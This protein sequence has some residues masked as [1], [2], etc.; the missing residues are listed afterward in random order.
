MNN[1]SKLLIALALG[2]FLFKDKIMDVFNKTP[3]PI[4][5]AKE[6]FLYVKDKHGV[7]YAKDIERLFRL[8]TAHFTSGQ[9]LGTGSAGME[10]TKETFPFGWS[11]EEFNK[12]HGL[13]PNDYFI[14]YY[15][16]NHTG[17][18]TPF[19]GWK[20]TGD[21]IKFVAW[22]IKNKRNGDIL[23]WYRLPSAATKTDRENYRKKLDA[24]KTQFV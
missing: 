10:A 1:K 21:N 18:R 5:T 15:N 2:V 16:D 4:G 13:S 3:K 23:S 12:L 20:K 8:E 19:V 24:I 17:K 14:K 7:E 6:G 9:W 11:L 22:F